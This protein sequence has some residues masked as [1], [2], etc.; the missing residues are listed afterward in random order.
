MQDASFVDVSNV[1][2]ASY[3]HYCI[4]CDIKPHE[5]HRTIINNY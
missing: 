3:F 5:R 1:P 2:Q 4:I